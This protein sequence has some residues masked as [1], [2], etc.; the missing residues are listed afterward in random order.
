MLPLLACLALASASPF[1]G[2]RPR[3]PPPLCPAVTY[4][5]SGT[6]SRCRHLGGA[7]A[8][9]NTVMVDVSAV[10]AMEDEVARHVAN[11]AVCEEL[12]VCLGPA[13]GPGGRF[14]VL[15]RLLVDDR[16]Q[17]RGNPVNNVHCTA[18]CRREIALNVAHA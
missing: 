14:N 4:I 17:V 3:P 15:L 1:P 6:D 5:Y 9:D 16:P 11:A 2:R 18:K 12:V 10:L 8:R 13:E 7:I